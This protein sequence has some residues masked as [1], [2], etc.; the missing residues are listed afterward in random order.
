MKRQLNRRLVMK[1]YETQ[2]IRNV[3]FL[4]HGGA[5]KTT[6]AEAVAFATKD[7]FQNGTH[8]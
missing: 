5:G 7:Y 6:F 4:G 2:N 8:R 1:I 3:V